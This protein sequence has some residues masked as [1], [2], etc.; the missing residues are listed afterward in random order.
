M[1]M[2]KEIK[3]KWS[4]A[5]IFPLAL[6]SFCLVTAKA[7]VICVDGPDESHFGFP[8]FWLM[9][10]PTSLSWVVD[11][12]A[13]AIDFVIYLL[14]W[15]LLSRTPI[16]TKLFSWRPGFLLTSAWV[17]AVLVSVTFVLLLSIGEVFAGG[18][19]FNRSYECPKT[20]QYS[21]VLG[22]PR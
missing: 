7:V 17:L 11:V 5:R 22:F 9:P 6:L 4:A 19:S 14:V 1:R 8:F 20:K 3:W 2:L 12:L 15:T 10:G 16:F 13:L 18:V 21:F